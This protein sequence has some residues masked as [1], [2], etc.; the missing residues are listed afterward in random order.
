MSIHSSPRTLLQSPRRHCDK[1]GGQ[2]GARK[3]FPN[4]NDSKSNCKLFKIAQKTVETALSGK[5]G[6]VC[7][8]VC[9]YNAQE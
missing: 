1:F 8:T 7:V 4:I 9:F 6:K 3:V 5:I 2:C